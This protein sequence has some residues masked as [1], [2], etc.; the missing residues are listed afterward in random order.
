MTR[1]LLA[2]VPR[3]RSG[4]PQ[5][6]ELQPLIDSIVVTDLYTLKQCEFCGQDVWVG[7]RQMAAYTANPNGFQVSCFLD[8]VQVAT[9]TSG[10]P[11]DPDSDVVQ[12][13]GGYP[14]EGRPRV[15]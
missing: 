13:G 7:P 5:A 12:L 2:C 1:Q 6:P 14:V 10:A 11:L 9:I 3:D 8:A 15:T 4:L